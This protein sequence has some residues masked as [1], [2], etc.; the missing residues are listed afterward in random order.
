[1]LERGQDQ[2]DDG[3]AQSLEVRTDVKG[4]FLRRMATKLTKGKKSGLSSPTY[5]KISR[6]VDVRVHRAH[7]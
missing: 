6:A 3:D 5:T 7:A 4:S 2:T 1:M